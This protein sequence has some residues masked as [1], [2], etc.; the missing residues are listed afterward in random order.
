M[1]RIQEVPDVPA[2]ESGTFELNIP[3]KPKL[4]PF[5]KKTFI[6]PIINEADKETEAVDKFVYLGTK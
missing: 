3:A 6:R 5:A 4:C 2:E 1:V